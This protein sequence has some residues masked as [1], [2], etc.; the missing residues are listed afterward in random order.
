MVMFYFSGTGNS[1]YIAE[2]FCQN[3]EASCYSIEDKVDFSQLINSEVIIGFCYP[4]YGSRVPR[5]M[6]QFVQRFL[7]ELKGKKLIIFAT[8]LLFSGDGARVLTDLF[9][10]NY[11]EVFYADH[12]HMPN[13]V[14][15]F[16]LLGQRSKKGI[17]KKL[18]K[19]EKKL[20]AICNDIKLG[21]VKR[22]GFSAL[23]K[24]LGKIQGNLWQKDSK[25][26]DL[27]PGSMEEKI[28]KSVRVSQ[29][30]T[31]CSICVRSCPV[32]NLKL[33][34][35]SIM[36]NNNC[37]VCYRCVNICPERAISVMLKA[38]PKWQYNRLL[39][40]EKNVSV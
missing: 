8:Q 16:F 37:V 19:A 26:V 13:N 24:F 38:K 9:P 28:A 29:D 2:L 35:K 36:H 32:K 7:P 22:R 17:E 40:L 31:L 39:K 33:E 15:N 18:L 10:E 21:K 6:R 12:F 20:I 34:N 3:M 5:N 23:S 14:S 25:S 4:I 30:C 1:K 27:M 11:I